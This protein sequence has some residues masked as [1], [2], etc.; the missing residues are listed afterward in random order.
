MISKPLIL[1]AAFGSISCTQKQPSLALSKPS[2]ENYVNKSINPYKS[3]AQIPLPDGFERT[4]YDTNSFSN[5]IRNIALKE[6]KTVYLYNGNKKFNQSAQYAIMDISVGKKDLQQCADA[7]MRLRGEYLFSEKKFESIFFK[8][9]ANSAYQFFQPYT[10]E[11]FNKYLDRVFGM[12]GSASLSKQ[13]KTISMKELEVG[14]VFIRGGFPGHAVLVVDVAENKERQK[15][16]LLAQSYMPAQDIHILVNPVDEKLSPW[17]MV[18]D[19]D[20]II[21]PEYYFKRNE[22]KTWQ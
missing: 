7:V 22:L 14:D 13:L 1:F 4:K 19:D 15:I 5:W 16:Y 9:N 6:N 2:P 11:N 10:R 8:D 21:T 18:N 20:D 17:Y 3:I 12:C